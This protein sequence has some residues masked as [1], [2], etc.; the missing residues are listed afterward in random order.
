MAGSR[1]QG[2]FRRVLLGSVSTH[3][4]RDAACPVIVVPRGSGEGA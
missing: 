2:P 3:L 1:A 4:L